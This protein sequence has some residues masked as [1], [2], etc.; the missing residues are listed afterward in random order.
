V[1]AMALFAVAGLIGDWFLA[2]ASQDQIAAL[3]GS[4]AIGVAGYGALS[5]LIVL[6]AVVTAATSR[7]TVYRTLRLME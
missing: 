5:G 6:V 3:F 7:F 1:T 4:F 2:T